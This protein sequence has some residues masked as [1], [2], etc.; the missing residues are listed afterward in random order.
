VRRS[1][2][3]GVNF[4][5]GTSSG[6]SPYARAPGGASMKRLASSKGQSISRHAARL[7]NLSIAGAGA[8]RQACILWYQLHDVA[9]GDS[10]SLLKLVCR[11]S[12]TAHMMACEGTAAA[13]CD[14]VGSMHLCRMPAGGGGDGQLSR[15]R[16]LDKT[17]YVGDMKRALCMMS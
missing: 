11:V 16:T 10:E 1:E 17:T 15:S 9:H 6:A 4:Q 5:A 8:I 7:V 14:Q 13:W 12:R 3:R 2:G